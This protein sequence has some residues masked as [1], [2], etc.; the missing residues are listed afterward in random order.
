MIQKSEMTSD[1]V[2]NVYLDNFKASLYYL[3]Q[4]DLYNIS[5]IECFNIKIRTLTQAC[6]EGLTWSQS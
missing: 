3:P 5:I 4:G 6:S 1:K 2:D